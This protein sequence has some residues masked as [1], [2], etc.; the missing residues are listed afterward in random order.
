MKHWHTLA[1]RELLAQRVTSVLILLAVVLSTMMTAVIGQSLGVLSAMRQQQAIA[2][3]GN[4][5]AGFVQM[6]AAQVET[7][8]NDPRLSFVGTT[9]VLGSVR[10]DNTLK[11]GLSEF[12]EDVSAVYP[13]ISA[14]KSGR[15]PEAPM[16]IALPEDVLGYL[17]FAG[18]LGDTLTLSPSK[19]LRHGVMTQTFDFTAEFT[20]VGITESNYMNYAAG[21]VNGIVGPGTVEALLP[22]DYIYYNVDVRMADKGTFQ[23]V[24]DD[25]VS[26]LN[27]HE[28]D[29]LYNIPLLDA[30]GIRYSA[31]A[32]GDVSGDGFPFMAAAGALVGGLVLLA[33]GLVIY[34]ILKI[35][36]SRRMTQYG[37]L[38]C[39]GADRRQLYSLV[40]GQVLLLCALGI[41]LGLLL[42]ALSA[43]GILTAATGLLSPKIF[44]VNDAGELNRLIAENSGGKG[45]FLLASAAVTL[46]FA[47]A[48]ALPAARYAARVAPTAAMA[49]PRVRIRRRGRRAKSIRNFEAFYARLNLRRSPGRTAITVL[50]LVMSITVFITLQSAVVLLNSAGES[51]AEHYGDY[52]ITNET[53]GFSPEE[54]RAMAEDPRVETLAAMQ[55][56][57]YEQGSGGCPEGIG[58]SVPL[59]PAETFQVVG[60]N[61]AYWD[62]AFSAL[63]PETLESLKAGEGCMVR[64]PIPLVYEGQEIP[65]TSIRAGDTVTVAGRELT[66]LHTLDG[67]D[68]YLSV[69]NNG[70]T[71][72][73]QM[74][75]NEELYAALTGRREYNWLLPALAEGTDRAE[76]D[77][78][79]E[80][81]AGRVPGTLWLS[82]EDTDRQL[83][84]SFRQIQLLAWGLILFV[85]LIG[86]L[87]IVN[88]V[89]TNIHTRVAEIGMQ[90][91]VGMS[92]GSLFRV[93]LWEGA[94]YGIIA[95]AAGSIAGYLCTVL[96]EAAVTD[97]LR[98]A[99]VPVLPI[100]EASALATAACLLATCVPL[101][102]ISGMSIVDSI[103]TAE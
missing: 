42:G 53:A 85:A 34:N 47:L 99:A 89:Y 73:V 24:M 1:L 23:A 43:K 95:S 74:I 6:D 41:P 67:Y 81:L 76:F 66:V 14:L 103:E 17:G 80:A 97:E 52:S 37:V 78:A 9:V 92:A 90:R 3:G 8:R 2:I 45:A 56:S 71:N 101:R 10:L 51:T 16:E 29:A 83:A 61:G 18:R 22:E 64:N 12:Q 62:R 60:L 15:L 93:F 21:V 4:R 49:G 88:T 82:F 102:R 44:L 69:G 65:R 32:A 77:A 59:Q 40:T 100:L 48:A 96:V 5:H 38:R 68:T 19:A 57:L 75:V 35:A 84:E 27:V 58:F 20:L 91:A 7:L 46:V 87:N 33:A 25:I 70:F 98:L 94:Y 50:S 26:A 72:G 28:L 55:F 63:P 30:L 86:L 39:L 11:L 13:S 79:A 36:V 54:Y 31:E